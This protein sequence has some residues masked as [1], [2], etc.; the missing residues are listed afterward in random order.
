MCWL[1]N[2]T[3]TFVTI[4]FGIVWAVTINLVVEILKK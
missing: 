3:N 4:A 2:N 1:E